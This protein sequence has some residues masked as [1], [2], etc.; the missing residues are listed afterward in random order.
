MSLKIWLHLLVYENLPPLP[1]LC[2]IYPTM[3]VCILNDEAVTLVSIAS[4]ISEGNNMFLFASSEA[5]HVS[6]Q[7]SSQSWRYDRG[8]D[9]KGLWT[10]SECNT[11]FHTA[12][13]SYT[14]LSSMINKQKVRKTYLIKMSRVQLPSFYS[15][16]AG[17]KRDHMSFSVVGNIEKIDVKMCSRQ[18]VLQSIR[19]IQI[20][21]QIIQLLDILFNSGLTFILYLFCKSNLSRCFE[22]SFIG[23]RHIRER[24]LCSI[25]AYYLITNSHKYEI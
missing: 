9:Y 19:K 14:V 20:F 1:S 5:Q 6:C 7:R 15:Q 18:F 17:K 24:N 12:S 8:K 3:V 23:S 10:S 21:E 22:T 11:S 13:E 25:C 4:F 16:E 2:Q